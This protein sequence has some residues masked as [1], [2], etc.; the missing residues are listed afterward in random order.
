MRHTRCSVARCDI[1]RTEDHLIFRAYSNCRDETRISLRMSYVYPCPGSET[2]GRICAAA[3]AASHRGGAAPHEKER[4]SEGGET[5][6]GEGSIPLPWSFTLASTRWENG[7]QPGDSDACATLQRP[8]FSNSR[9]RV[10]TL[11]R[12][13]S[14]HRVQRE[15]CPRAWIIC[16]VSWMSQSCALV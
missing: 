9:I 4:V 1:L 13:V 10:A 11:R 14:K 5:S 16:L 7:G 12:S 15:P 2:F 6:P 8:T 3:R